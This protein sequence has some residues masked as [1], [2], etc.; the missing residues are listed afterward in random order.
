M[1]ADDNVVWYMLVNAIESFQGLRRGAIIPEKK[2]RAAGEQTDVEA[3]S[4][5]PDL[6]VLLGLR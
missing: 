4:P 5:S 6:F 3:I 1:A 2:L